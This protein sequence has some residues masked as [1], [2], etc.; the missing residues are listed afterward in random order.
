M[1]TPNTPI[2]VGILGASSYTGCEL[3]RLLSR[4][5]GIQV[6]FVSSRSYAGTPLSTIFPALR[7][8]C[9]R[10]CITPEDATAAQADC[11]FSCLPHGVSASYLLP[12][13]ERGIR[14]ID[15][16]ADF[17]LQDAAE[18][19]RWYGKDHPAPHL[20]ST[21]VYGLV[22]HFRDRIAGAAIVANPGCYPTGMLL[23]LLPLAARGGIDT[24]RGPLI[25]DAKSGL[26]GAGRALKLTSHFVEA[27]E[28]MSAYAAGQR[29]R[30]VS[31]MRRLLGDA[32]AQAGT[33]MPHFIFTPHL[34]PVNRGI[35]STIYVP[36]TI[37]ART[38][39]HMLEEAYAAQRFI[40]VRPFGQLPA[41]RDV[42][43]SNY[44]DIGVTDVPDQDTVIIV[45]AIDNLTRGASGQ[46]IQNMNCMM[47]FPEHT[48]L[49]L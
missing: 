10:A 29:H 12:F 43:Y 20:L 30:H 47:G 36:A 11:V 49:G 16:S 6:A 2:T 8:I 45:S 24:A 5:D 28:S 44:C 15:L 7:G 21:A 18:Y 17:R 13:I 1:T 34:L 48:A 25:T 19:A 26:S 22:E 14:V 27:N 23:P 35:L 4:H 3:L 32:C 39:H 31:E 42:V 33:E 40:R 9:D 41:L 46:A 38:C 37:D